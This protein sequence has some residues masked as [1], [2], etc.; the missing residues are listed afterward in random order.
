MKKNVKLLG[1]FLFVFGSALVFTNQNEKY[2]YN[3]SEISYMTTQ[4]YGID[5]TEEDLEFAKEMWK[6][7]KEYYRSTDA[8][9]FFMER[10][11]DFQSLLD[12]I[13]DY[14]AR[15]SITDNI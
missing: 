5:F 1:M 11:W 12:K 3:A 2:E 9:K 10:D 14:L 13:D 7:F 15:F 6:D 8:Y 4:E